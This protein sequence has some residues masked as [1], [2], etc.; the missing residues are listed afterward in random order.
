MVR[1]FS[2]VNGSVVSEF[3][4]GIANV[5]DQR[6]YKLFAFPIRDAGVQVQS[7]F[8]GTLVPMNGSS[9]DDQRLAEKRRPITRGFESD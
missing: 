3:C 7:E 5:R 1:R 6:I 4:I 8:L 2:P 9:A